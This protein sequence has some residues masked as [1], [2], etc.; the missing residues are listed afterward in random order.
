[1][2][3]PRRQF[4]ATAAASATLGV[5]AAPAPAAQAPAT[6]PASEPEAQ[7]ASAPADDAV[8]IGLLQIVSHKFDTEA[9]R[10]HAH[11][12]IEGAAD[13][14]CDIALMPELYQIGYQGP[15]GTSD[16]A[17]AEWRGRAIA[18]DD[19]WIQAFRDQARRRRIAIA[20]T[21]L[22]RMD[23][24]ATPPRNSLL[25]IDREGRDA[26]LYA[27][28]HT[29]DFAP[30]EAI[31]SPGTEWP[32]CDLETRAGTVRVGSMICFDREFPESA[33]SLMLG[34]AELILTPN[35][36]LLDDLRLAQFQ[37]RA[38]ENSLAVAMANYPAPEHNGRSVAYG[39][40]GEPLVE[41]GADEQSAI[42]DIHLGHLRAYRARTIWGDAFRRPHRYGMLTEQIRL[43]VFEREDALGRPYDKSQR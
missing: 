10:Q 2:H 20:A 34:G 39:G 37:V 15:A 22:E 31:C 8:R 4:L 28:V 36:C 42:A 14:G 38:L 5:A 9:N 12:A 16:E 27:K 41:A 23:G 43:P 24:G 6:R 32:V 33:R 40:A 11:A 18:L 19:P 21:F 26:L 35:A 25:L 30:V 29:I 3:I 1:M 7:P 13:A 17:I